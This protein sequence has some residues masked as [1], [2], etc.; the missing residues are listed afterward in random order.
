MLDI[1]LGGRIYRMRSFSG[2][3]GDED[4]VQFLSLDNWIEGGVIVKRG[5]LEKSWIWW[6]GYEFFRGFIDVEDFV[7]SQE[8]CLVGNFFRGVW[9]IVSG[10]GW[11]D[12]DMGVVS[13]EMD[14]GVLGMNEIMW[15]DCFG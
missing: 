3:Q 6:Q 14:I 15:G 1:Y 2:L 13:L 7:D 4:D 11:E 9:S 12:R 5:N 10:L 8:E